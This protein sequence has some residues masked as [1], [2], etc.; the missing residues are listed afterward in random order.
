LPYQN[1]VNEKNENKKMNYNNIIRKTGLSDYLGKKI[2]KIKLI[3][4]KSPFSNKQWTNNFN[5]TFQ[6]SI[7]NNIINIIISLISYKKILHLFTRTFNL[8]LDP[9]ISNKE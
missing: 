2:N 8:F 6:I 1:K 7:T 5:L 3:K 4:L 9:S